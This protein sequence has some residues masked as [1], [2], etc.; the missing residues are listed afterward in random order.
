MTFV[1]ISACNLGEVNCIYTFL[2]CGDVGLCSWPKEALVSIWIEHQQ[3]SDHLCKICAP[4]FILS[5]RPDTLLRSFLSWTMDCPLVR[6]T[7][8]GL[9]RYHQLNNVDDLT[10]P[11]DNV[12]SQVSGSNVLGKSYCSPSRS[13]VMCILSGRWHPKSTWLSAH[14]CTWWCNVKVKVLL[15]EVYDIGQRLAFSELPPHTYLSCSVVLIPLQRSRYTHR[16][17]KS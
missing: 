6:I 4:V 1:T 12:G 5:Y 14:C 11:G 16:R 3:I 9:K 7:D 8:V 10:V 13:T 2:L 17:T 15:A